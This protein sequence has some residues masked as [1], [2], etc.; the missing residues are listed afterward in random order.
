[1]GVAPKD[2]FREVGIGGGSLDVRG[3]DPLGLCDPI[4]PDLGER[5]CCEK[6]RKANQADYGCFKS[7]YH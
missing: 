7:V 1:M 5:W 3:A 2:T 4:G 6:T